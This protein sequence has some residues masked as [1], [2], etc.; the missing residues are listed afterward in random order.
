MLTLSASAANRF[1]SN[2]GTWKMKDESGQEM[3]GTCYTSLRSAIGNGHVIYV[4][5]DYD[6]TVDQ[7]D[8]GARY[9]F[10]GGFSS[11]IIR[12][13]SGDWRTGPTLSGRHDWETATG[14]G[15]NAFR[16]FWKTGLNSYGIQIIGFKILDGAA[17]LASDNADGYG[18]CVRG[19]GA[20]G[21]I[22]L[23]NCLVSGGA[24]YSGGGAYMCRLENC[25]VTNNYAHGNGGGLDSS[26]YVIDTLVSGNSARKSGGGASSGTFS[27]CVVSCNISASSGKCDTAGRLMRAA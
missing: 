13:E 14:I 21:R 6:C 4:K 22:T 10:G 15:T 27:N 2:D 9:Q 26:S 24:A 25:I 3:A 16:V 5:N 11:C 8:S 17:T 7:P 12:S 23:K 20:A 19:Y 1:V 18:G